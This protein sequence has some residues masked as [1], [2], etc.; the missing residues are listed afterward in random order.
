LI[1][2]T[3][4]LHLTQKVWIYRNLLKD[5]TVFIIHKQNN[6]LRRAVSTLK[7]PAVS[8]V[9]KVNEYAK[10]LIFPEITNEDIMCKIRI[11]P[12]ALY[13]CKT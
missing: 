5:K 12:V 7:N 1:I 2:S 11:L 8:Q 6:T 10:N 3:F 4:Y 9:E 13:G